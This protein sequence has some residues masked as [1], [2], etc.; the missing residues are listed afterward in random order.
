[1]QFIFQIFLKY[2]PR[3]RTIIIIKRLQITQVP[4]KLNFILTFHIPQAALTRRAL[5]GKT[6]VHL[7]YFLLIAL[8]AHSGSWPLIQFRNYFYTDGRIPWTSEQPVARPLPKHRTTQTQNKRLHPPNIHAL[9]G[10][11][12]HDPSVR[13]NEDSSCLRPRGYCDRPFMERWWE[14]ITHKNLVLRV[15]I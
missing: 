2:Y 8:P 11:R 15:S 1:M 13:A 4:T 5:K 3:Y 9:I 12:A 6:E 7:C 14:N 10:I